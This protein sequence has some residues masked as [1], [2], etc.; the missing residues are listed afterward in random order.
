MKRR[1][2]GRLLAVVALMTLP[3]FPQSFKGV[4]PSQGLAF[5]HLVV[6]GETET[7]VTLIAQGADRS[8]GDV[9]IYTQSGQPLPVL[10]DGAGPM[11]EF[12]YSLSS[13]SSANYRLTLNQETLNVGFAVVTQNPVGQSLLSGP[14][15]RPQAQS[16]SIGGQV[17]FRIRSGS[18]VVS[19]VAS[20]SA[21][22]L[23]KVHLVFDNTG[24]NRTA[25]AMASLVDNEL[26][27]TRYSETGTAL[28]TKHVQMTEMTQQALFIDEL[29]R[30]SQA[31]RGFLIIDAREPFFGLSL[32]QNGLLLST[33]GLL[34]GV[35]ERDIEISTLFG[36]L[37]GTLRL[38]QNGTFLTGTLRF[39]SA[40]EPD[41]LGFTFCVT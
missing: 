23:S 31:G 24:G 12:S 16:G 29:F 11:S 7:V 15:T 19:Q 4:I 28:E 21:Q 36:E 17:R 14:E 6:G 13:R 9:K 37:K 38:I 30:G 2:L 26:A 27:V 10:V 32:D 33:G 8:E 39:I 25:L 1:M 40:D 41:E 5:P 22:V 3:T 18:E 20:L 35:I 34:P